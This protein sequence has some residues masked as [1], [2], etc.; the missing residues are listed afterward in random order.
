METRIF[1][2]NQVAIGND[3]QATK[4][5]FY[6]TDSTSGVVWVVKPGQK[7]PTHMHTTSDDVWICMQGKG[8]F[9]PEEG[10][11]VEISK[12][13]IIVSAKMNIME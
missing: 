4:T 13:D 5:P 1:K 9:Y 6:S 2:L 12:G 3:N 8:V 10:K 11:E 7:V